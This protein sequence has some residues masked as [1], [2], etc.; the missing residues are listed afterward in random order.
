MSRK[1][2]IGFGVVIVFALLV[3]FGGVVREPHD[4]LRTESDPPMALA[5]RRREQPLASLPPLRGVDALPTSAVMP[6]PTSIMDPLS[7]KSTFDGHTFRYARHKSLPHPSC[8]AEETL[9]SGKLGDHVTLGITPGVRF[10]VKKY[11]SRPK[12]NCFKHGGHY[13]PGYS[14]KEGDYLTLENV[15]YHRGVYFQAT[16]SG[17][18]EEKEMVIPF[19]GY[20]SMVSGNWPQLVTNEFH[21]AGSLPSDLKGKLNFSSED[22]YQQVEV[23]YHQPPTDYLSHYHVVVEIV[24][25]A[26]HRMWREGYHRNVVAVPEDTRHHGVTTA[27]PLDPA[28]PAV[29]VLTS[30][31][32]HT[33]YG[34]K[35][36]ACA[37]VQ[38]G[39]LST[40]WGRMF[41]V[42]FNRTLMS[43]A[44]PVEVEK[45]ND[46]EDALLSTATN[47]SSSE[48]RWIYG[49]RSEDPQFTVVANIESKMRKDL[50][51]DK[52]SSKSREVPPSASSKPMFIRRLLVGNPTHCEPLWGPDAFYVEAAAA[53]VKE[54]ESFRDCQRLLFGFRTFY[55]KWAFG[56]GVEEHAPYGFDIPIQYDKQRAGDQIEVLFATRKGDWARFI[57]NED[58]LIARV[59]RHLVSKYPAALIAQDPERNVVDGVRAVKF[60]NGTLESQIRD[61]NERTTIFLTNHGANIVP[62]LYMRPNAGLITMSLS[63]PGFYPFSVYPT[64]LHWRDIEIDQVCNRRLF[65]KQCK[66]SAAN[67][68]DNKVNDQQMEVI[69]RFIDQILEAQKAAG[70]RPDHGLTLPR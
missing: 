52:K 17:E 31:P 19:S 55:L 34:F 44:P 24:A 64:W 29:T 36:K 10:E 66:L 3:Y 2:A 32:M 62:S 23:A 51:Q 63:S 57:T 59:R 26:F 6:D 1:L 11:Y 38:E 48:E 50:N 45:R 20:F 39:C 69:L 53:E 18:M 14:R 56:Y 60:A 41:S 9:R 35:P 12:W 58:F 43:G 25:T 33:R 27:S 67:N 15:V 42:I 22:D 28:R 65:P 40:H 68:N 49:L 37:L 21:I 8:L 7:T 54:T 46:A 61:V 30:R 5:P 16:A 13:N 70:G 4:F 47:H